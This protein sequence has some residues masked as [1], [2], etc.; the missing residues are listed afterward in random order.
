MKSAEI[1][2][3]FSNLTYRVPERSHCSH[4]GFKTILKNVSGNFNSGQEM[5]D[6]FFQNYGYL[7]LH[8]VHNC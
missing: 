3:E 1:N 6:S 2:I 4:R 8:T 5:F 7:Q